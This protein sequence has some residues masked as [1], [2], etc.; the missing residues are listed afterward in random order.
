[1]SK[2]E[3]RT[4]DTDMKDVAVGSTIVLEDGSLATVTTVEARDIEVKQVRKV[5]YLEYEAADKKGRKQRWHSVH[6]N[7][8]QVETVA[9]PFS[10]KAWLLGFFPTT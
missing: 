9:L 6:E 3:V 4:V 8:E 7:D 1:M 10:I 5:F 2:R